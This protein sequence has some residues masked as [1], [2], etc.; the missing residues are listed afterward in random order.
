MQNK[1]EYLAPGYRV[2]QGLRF[3]QS[4]IDYTF[5]L[6]CSHLKIQQL[7]CLS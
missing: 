3:G 5:F 4:D 2:V 1:A 7:H 6:V